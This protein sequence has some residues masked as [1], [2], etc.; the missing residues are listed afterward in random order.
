MSGLLA[1]V[2]PA[3]TIIVEKGGVAW[4]IPLATTLFVALVA[5]AVSYCATWRFKL[6]DVNRE[7]ASRVAELVYEAEQL[8]ARR[9]RYS[10]APEGGARTT[11]FLLQSA[12]IRAQPLAEIDPG[13]DDRLMAAVSFNFELLLWDE[14]TARA[15]HWLAEAIANVRVALVPQLTAP[16][17]IRRKREAKR[18]FPTAE[19][20]HAMPNNDPRGTELIDALVDWRGHRATQ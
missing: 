16:N 12:R 5:A 8:V 3:R 20:L 15:L 11:L 1:A 13:L 17:L 18:V 14:E 6:A 9:E 7:S 10:A 2:E 19:E 4:W